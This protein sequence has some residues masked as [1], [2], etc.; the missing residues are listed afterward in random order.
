MVTEIDFEA[1]AKRLAT[2]NSQSNPNLIKVYWFPDPEHKSLNIL[3]VEDGY[4]TSPAT[5]TIDVFTFANPIGK[6]VVPLSMGTISPNLDH[7]PVLPKNWVNWE[8]AKLLWSK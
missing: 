2:E 8:R 7:K 3:N 1:E 4:F 6:D 5:E